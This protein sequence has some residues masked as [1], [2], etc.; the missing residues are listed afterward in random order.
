[1]QTDLNTPRTNEL[2]S[3][4]KLRIEETKRIGS[5]STRTALNIVKKAIP[6]VFTELEAIVEDQY[7]KS[8]V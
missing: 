7:N 4:I 5:V 6:E 8:M 1:M 2:L 3:I